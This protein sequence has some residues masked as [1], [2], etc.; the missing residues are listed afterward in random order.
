MA[1]RNWHIMFIHIYIYT[2]NI[3]SRNTK[4]TYDFLVKV[5]NFLLPLSLKV[6][7]HKEWIHILSILAFSFTPHLV[8]HLPKAFASKWKSTVFSRGRSKLHSLTFSKSPNPP[9][10]RFRCMT[11]FTSTGQPFYRIFILTSVND[12]S[13]PRASTPVLKFAPN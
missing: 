13:S 1:T 9:H 4:N 3:G 8:R 5:R 10:A 2:L 12:T 6:L 11:S 7:R